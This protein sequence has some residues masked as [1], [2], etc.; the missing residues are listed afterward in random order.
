MKPYLTRLPGAAGSWAAP[1]FVVAAWLFA[2]LL[3]A[4]L[5][6]WRPTVSAFAYGFGA[7]FALVC[8]FSAVRAGG[9][10]SVFWVLL[11]AALLLR[12]FGD[13]SWGVGAALG[14]G[15][16][17]LWSVYGIYGA[18]YVLFLAAVLKLVYEA[19]RRIL[20]IVALDAASIMLSVGVLAWYFALGPATIGGN[21]SW[22]GSIAILSS[23]A[24]GAGLL[25]LCLTILSADR[26][27]PFAGILATAFGAFFLADGLYLA[28]RAS[29]PYTPGGWP[30]MVWALG[31]VL[32]GLAALASTPGETSAR[33]GEISP[34]RVFSFWFGPLSPAV[35][36]AFLLGWGAT[37]PP[38]PSYVLWGGAAITLYLA[39]RISFTT[40]VSR[41]IRLDSQSLAVRGEQG[42]I[43]EELHDTLKQSVYSV[44]T[45]LDAYE[46]AREKED[47]KAED[48]L[49]DAIEASHA[50]NFQVGRPIDELRARWAGEKQDPSPLLGR[51]LTDFE[52]H[53]SIRP[54]EDLRADL[55]KLCPDELAAAYRIASEALWNAARH[56]GARNVWLES[57]EVGPLTIV[58]IRDD[59]RGFGEDTASGYG[60]SLMRDRAESSGGSLDI[61]SDALSG[62]TVQIRFEK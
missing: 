54:H 29:G 37:D 55:T 60:L 48:V 34:W 39:F 38:L 17:P 30:E 47:P 45:L 23:F 18:S 15:T 42:R 32:F 10:R 43:S 4:A 50:A 24:C 53:F 21:G 27:P 35:H 46:K 36:F 26:R 7:I 3:F 19:S 2:A 14:L 33:S 5:S 22:E 8:V 59:G 16:L 41:G 49:A 11:G 1:L 25:F 28:S 40:Y 61:I 13:A 31:L 58:R 44:S 57:R 62:T 6:G 20:F 9:A 51:L 56:S 12:L 52:T